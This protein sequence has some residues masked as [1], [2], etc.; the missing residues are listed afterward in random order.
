MA[1]DV[2]IIKGGV[3]NVSKQQDDVEL[4]NPMSEPDEKFL[5]L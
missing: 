1:G 3:S 5:Q 4:E 2:R